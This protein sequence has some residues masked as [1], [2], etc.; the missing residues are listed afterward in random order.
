MLGRGIP[1]SCLLCA[2]SQVCSSFIEKEFLKA[3]V[4]EKYVSLYKLANDNALKSLKIPTI[5]CMARD[6]VS[7]ARVQDYLEDMT[8]TC[9]EKVILHEDVAALEEEVSRGYSFML[10]YMTFL[11]CKVLSIPL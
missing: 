8:K 2:S 3:G 10:D 9:L 4:C 7:F 11:K 6:F 5:G 1:L